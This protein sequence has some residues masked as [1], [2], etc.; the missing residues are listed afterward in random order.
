MHPQMARSTTRFFFVLLVSIVVGLHVTFFLWQHQCHSIINTDRAQTHIRPQT[1]IEDLGNR[2]LL[3]VGVITAE[4]IV[5]NKSQSSLRYVG[6]ECSR[7]TNILFKRRNWDNAW[8][9]GYHFTQCR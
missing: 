2:K 7:Y 4:Q 1:L 5:E 9:A 3:F 8:F 6:Q